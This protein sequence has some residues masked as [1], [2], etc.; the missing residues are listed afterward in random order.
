MTPKRINTL[1]PN[2]KKPAIT[3]FIFITLGTSHT[4]KLH[5]KLER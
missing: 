4:T 5:N 1:T 3:S 2:H